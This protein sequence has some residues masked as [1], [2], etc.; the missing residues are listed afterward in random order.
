M[1]QESLFKFNVRKTVSRT[2]AKWDSYTKAYGTWMQTAFHDQ[3]KVKVQVL[4]A[5]NHLHNNQPKTAVHILNT[6]LKMLCKTSEEK[7]AW[8]FFMGIAHEAMEQYAQAFLYFTEAKEYE[9]ESPVILQKSADC[10]YREGLFGVAAYD[11][12]E[13][14]RLLEKEPDCN[15]SALSVLYASLSLC[16]TMTHEYQSAEEALRNA[17]KKDASSPEAQSAKIL[18]YAVHKEIEKADAVLHL[19][20][21]QTNHT[22]KYGIKQQIE[23]IRS[24]TNEQFCT[25]DVENSEIK[26]FWQ[27]FSTRLATYSAILDMNQAEEISKMTSEISIRLKKVFPFTQHPIRVCAYK[28][29]VCS[30]FVS[31]LYAQAL[32]D[33][34]TRLF[35]QAP[36]AIQES[37]RWIKIH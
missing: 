7:T 34:L 3:K 36:E 2:D 19:F 18:L 24:G 9:Q 15:P 35:A 32:S 10:A 8:L 20:L 28:N 27:W 12:E 11:Y 4:R 14:I 26:A 1:P 33:G 23:A 25:I 21:K 31:D 16:L 37:V 30:F 29:E 6:E 5:L 22:D 17:E 13:A